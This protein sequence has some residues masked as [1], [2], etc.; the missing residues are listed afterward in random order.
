MVML[1]PRAARLALRYERLRRER[2]RQRVRIHEDYRE[3]PIDWIVEKLGVDRE[4]LVWS[5]NPGYDAHQWDGT[6]DP[7]VAIA[8]GLVAWEDVGV[9]SGTGTGKSFFAACLILWFLACWE[10]ARVFTFAPKEDQLRLYI[11]TEMRKLWPRFQELFPLA[12]LL[13]LRIRMLPGSDEW[14]AVGY[15]VGIEAG[16]DSATRAQGMHAEHMLLVYEEMPGIPL[17]VLT[18]GE[19]TVTAPHNLRLGLGNPD[20]Q[21][22]TLHQFCLSPGVR[23]VRI[24]AHDHPNVV[25][26]QEVVPGAVSRVRVQRRRERYGEDSSLYKRRVRG[27]S[28]PQAEDAL[29]RWEWCEAAAAR[30]DDL[31]LRQ[32]PRALGVDVAASENGDRGAIARWLG[33]CL[34]EVVSFPCPD[35]VRLGWDVAVEMAISRVD[36][37]HV[38]V[39]SVGV[40]SGTVNKLKELN[41]YVN[42][43]NGGAR[44][45]PELEYV[46]DG[47][48]PVADEAKYAD[49]RAQMWWQLREDLQHGR[50]ALPRDEELFRDLTTPTWWTK[51]GKIWVESKEDIRKRLGRSPDKGDACVYGNWVRQRGK[52]Q[53]PEQ[54]ISAWDKHVL[55]H[56]AD[57][58]RR[59]GPQVGAGAAGPLPPDVGVF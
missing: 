37:M 22:D 15:A 45:E 34:L 11:W 10:G 58:S 2:A 52:V 44:P 39:D 3:R 40:G 51:A 42:A 9:E 6:P 25:T 36:P 50:I 20:S 16:K 56:E 7:L 48:V 14:G 53:E 41:C 30:Y 29:I 17:P 24:S 18:A 28:P 49:L 27:I 23:H 31:A 35:P 33:A 12:Q 55:E 54:P 21:H 19:N 4:S 5:M 46:E 59:I 43:L 26:G 8:E 1:S 38:G 32:G 13:D 57:Q 47:R